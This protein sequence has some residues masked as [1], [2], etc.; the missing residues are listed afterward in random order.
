MKHTLEETRIVEG[1]LKM[2]EKS[3]CAFF[4]SSALVCP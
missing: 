4:S 2:T 1:E 3:T